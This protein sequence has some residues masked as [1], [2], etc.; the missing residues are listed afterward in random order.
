MIRSEAS[1][2]DH[3]TDRCK[4]ARESLQTHLVGN[5]TFTD[6]LTENVSVAVL[7]LKVSKKSYSSR[8]HHRYNQSAV[9]LTHYSR[10]IQSSP[11][12]A[13]EDTCATTRGLLCLDAVGTCRRTCLRYG[14]PNSVSGFVATPS[15]RRHGTL[16]M[17]AARTLE[18]SYHCN[19]SVNAPNLVCP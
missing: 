11:K 17:N 12:Y 18:K 10:L 19:C 7:V 16:P 14:Q 4:G 1:R 6:G 5:M 8:Q 15:E 13:M 9:S 2:A 3:L